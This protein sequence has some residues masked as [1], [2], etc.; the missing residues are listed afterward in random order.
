MVAIGFGLP[1]KSAQASDGCI[2]LPCQPMSIQGAMP[3]LD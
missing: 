2:G 3:V 1:A